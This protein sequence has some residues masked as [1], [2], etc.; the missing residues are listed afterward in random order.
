MPTREKNG[1]TEFIAPTKST[2][3]GKI[4]IKWKRITKYEDE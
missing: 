4:I 3:D 1:I 2:L